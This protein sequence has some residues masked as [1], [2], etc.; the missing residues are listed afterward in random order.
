M[1]RPSFARARGKE[2]ETIGAIKSWT[3]GQP[4]PKVVE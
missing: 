2:A 4:F 3:L 1:A